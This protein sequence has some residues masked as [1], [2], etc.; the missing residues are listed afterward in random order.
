M[1]QGGRAGDLLRRAI[2]PRLHWIPGLRDRLLDSETPPLRR[3]ALV[4]RTR[5]PQVPQRTAVPERAP[6]GWH[7]VR[8][9]DPWRVRARDRRTALAPAAG[10]AGGPRDRGARGATR[11]APA[12]SGSQTARLRPHWCGRTSRCCGPAA[13]SQRSAKPPRDS[14]WLGETLAARL[15]ARPLLPAAHRDAMSGKSSTGALSVD[16]YL[17]GQMTLR[18]AGTTPERAE[19]PDPRTHRY[20]LTD[21]GIC[22]AVFYTKDHRPAARPADRRRSTPGPTRTPRCIWTQVAWGGIR[23]EPPFLTFED[24]LDLYAG[25]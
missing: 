16:T 23:P 10:C 13:T 1:T 14:G 9:R 24:R 4:E 12:H 6:G 3:S 15:A 25:T 8:R 21:E 5:T 22:I 20:V 19:P 7:P 2:A 18:Q 17:P 11:L